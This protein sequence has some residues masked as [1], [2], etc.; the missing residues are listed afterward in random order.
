MNTL[1]G[2]LT[3]CT[4]I[5]PGESWEKH[6]NALKKYVP[7]IKKEVSPN[8]SF[9]IGLRLSHKASLQLSKE[10]ELKT[11]QQWLHQNDCYIFT[12]NGF[13]YGNFHHTRVKD[14][15]HAPGWITNERLQYTLRLFRILAALLPEDL[16]GGVS[17]SP[18]SYKLWHK[19]TTEDIFEKCTWNII[20]VVAHLHQIYKST[21][22]VLHLDIEPEPDGL[23]ENSEEFIDW[24]QQ[25]LL[26]LGRTLLQDRCKLSPGEAEKAI[27]DHI[28]L[29]FDVCHFALEYENVDDVLKKLEAAEIRV[30]KWQLSSALKIDLP[31]KETEKEA[32]LSELR[33]FD[34]PVY[35]HQVIAKK[36]DGG[37]LH[38]PDLPEAFSDPKALNA[39]EWRSHYHVPL[40]V[41]EYGLLGSTREEVLKAL[42]AQS[43]QKVTGHL[44]VETY[45][46]DV[47]PDEL[48]MPIDESI[49]RELKWVIKEIVI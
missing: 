2:Q 5:F 17:T 25:Q 31:E 8:Q 30:G 26:P 41:K 47:L 20:E 3:F 21:G 9:G 43:R 48:K 22:K 4:N 40:F 12:M 29:C 45:T 38:Y 10:A 27:K 15:V 33:K 28:R 11:F 24:F 14:Q 19:E 23:L 46:W 36:K 32:V 7:S 35:L 6:F 49:I 16:D 13:P 42:E 1:A 37:L 18:L 44:E 34:E 39:V